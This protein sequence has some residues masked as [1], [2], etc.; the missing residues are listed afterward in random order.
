MEK[1]W[2]ALRDLKRPNALL[3]AYRQLAEENIEVFTPMRWRIRVRNG[4]QIRERVPVIQDLLFV[5]D[6][7]ETL[8][9]II[10]KTPTLQY[11][12]QRGGGYRQPIVVANDDM[13]RFIHAVGISEDPRYYL[14]DELTPAMYGRTVH[15]VGGPLD[16]YDGKLLTVRGSKVKRL[17]IELPDFFAVGVEVDP[18]YVQFVSR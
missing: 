8:D 6:T 7:R 13:R 17:L 16:G 9:P 12:F 3:P 18:D 4:R 2:Y 11:R 5:C 14:P 15:I 1:Q 10:G